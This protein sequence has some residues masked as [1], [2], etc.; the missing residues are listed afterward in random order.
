[1]RKK[2]SVFGEN[3]NDDWMVDNNWMRSC[4][5]NYYDSYCNLEEV[6]LKEAGRDSIGRENLDNWWHC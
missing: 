4:S 2:G 3:R 6:V 1:M 5:E